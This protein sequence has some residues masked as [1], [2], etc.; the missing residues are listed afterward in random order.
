MIN[1]KNTLVSNFELQKKYYR[2]K[3]KKGVIPVDNEACEEDFDPLPLEDPWPDP[4]DPPAP[5]P[6][7]PPPPPL[8]PE[9]W[10]VLFKSN[11]SEMTENG[12]R[13]RRP[14][15]S[16][17]AKCEGPTSIW[18]AVTDPDDPGIEGTYKLKL[19]ILG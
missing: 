18:E 10:L 16:K 11:R 19:N 1:S 2:K 9:V 4:N 7:P 15:L 13:H 5:P 14:S 8:P 12:R 3:T 6:P 17:N